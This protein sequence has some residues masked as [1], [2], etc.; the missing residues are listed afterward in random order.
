MNDLLVWGL[1]KAREQTLNLVAD[2]DQE[3]MC[4][5]SVEGENH[6]AWTLGHLFLADCMIFS[7]L[8][9]PDAPQLSQ[10][11]KEWWRAY[12]PGNA[13]SADK[14]RYHAKEELME[15]L[16]RTEQI[17]K[18]AIEKL[19]MED[20][21]R[22][23]PDPHFAITQPTIGHLLHYLLF[24][25]GNHAGQLASWRKTRKLPSGSGAFGVA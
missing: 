5:Q 12:A 17:R 3:Q 1:S 18:Q 19:T 14:N 22:P 25:E 16:I 20:L 7:V 24:H 11:P 15:K 10:L 9:V 2:L 21:S 6:P 23:T 13:P 8:Q 4:H